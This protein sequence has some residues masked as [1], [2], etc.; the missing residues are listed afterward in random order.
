[1][2]HL[3]NLL[4]DALISTQ[5]VDRCALLNKEDYSVKATSV[6]FQVAFI[7][8][9]KIKIYPEKNIK[10]SN[11]FKIAEKE[12]ELLIDSFGNTN[13]TRERG[14]Y[15]NEKHYSCLRSDEQSIYAKNVH[16]QYFVQIEC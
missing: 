2:N 11:V 3:Q 4:H 1:M 16:T 6:G 15:F 10:Y 13:L 5:N 8:Y 9:M 14:I 7:C 12:V